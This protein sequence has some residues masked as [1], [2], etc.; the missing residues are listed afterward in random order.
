MW[1]FGTLLFTV[2]LMSGQYLVEMTNLISEGASPPKVMTLSF[3]LIPGFLAKTIPMGMLLGTLLAF[4]R[5][6]GDSEIVAV[7]AAGA[8]VE[9]IMFPVAAFGL[10]ASL[11]T[12]GINE[13]VVPAASKQAIGVRSQIERELK[14]ARRQAMLSPLREGDRTVGYLMAED[15][16]ILT[17]TLRQVT[18]VTLD[19]TGGPS[20][21]MKADAIRFRGLKDW[22]VIGRADVFGVKDK[23]EVKISDGLWPS[24]SHPPEETFDDF[25]SRTLQKDLDVFTMAETRKQIAEMVRDKTIDPRDVANKWFGYW[26]KVSI[27]LSALVFGLLAAPLGIRNHRTGAAT[28]F[29]V[30][31]AIIFGYMM[32]A[33]VMNTLNQGGHVPAWAASFAPALLGLL[34]AGYL[35]HRR[36]QQ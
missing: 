17:Q 18:V 23:S 32:V 22:Q 31:I 7:R 15:T 28:G 19:A 29:A 8:S 2:L 36:N 34:A 6:S 35:V 11:V 27:P 9:R 26:N 21:V 10:F 5:L 14:R 4:G 20:T 33:N 30:S 24:G 16:D 3:L 12:F 25:V 1:V 13:V